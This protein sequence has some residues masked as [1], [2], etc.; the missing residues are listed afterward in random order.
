MF[1]K[2]LR[3]CLRSWVDSKG[4][5]KEAIPGVTILTPELIEIGER[6][7][8]GGQ[9]RIFN[10][11]FVKIGHDCMIAFGSQ[12]ITA[13]HDHCN[14][15]MWKHRVDRPVEIG[16]HVWIG[17]NSIILPGVKIGDYAVIG[18]GAVITA[19][20]PEKAIVGGNP[21]R[22]IGFRQLPEFDA[23][24]VYPGVVLKK[25]FFPGNKITKQK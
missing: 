12:I 5:K 11:E 22:I 8:F 25:G 4:A 18:A 3:Q 24:C 23:S 1:K 10:T 2:Y 16:N 13:T 9:V 17:T 20:V 7:S 19:H 6:V 14:H 21:A 15:P